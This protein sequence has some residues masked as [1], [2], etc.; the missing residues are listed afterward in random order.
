M[1]R[2]RR[3]ARPDGLCV[4]CVAVPAQGNAVTCYRCKAAEKVVPEY[5]N[6]P[7][8]WVRQVVPTAD[9]WKAI[10]EA[11]AQSIVWR[12]SKSG[13]GPKPWGMIQADVKRW[14]KLMHVAL[15]LAAEDEPWVR[16]RTPTRAVQPGS[17]P[18]ADCGDDKPRHRNAHRCAECQTLRQRRRALENERKRKAA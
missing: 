11:A 14:V 8:D 16:D 6:T 9:E 3:K 17:L 5:K 10:R 7:E 4:V 2:A 13:R 12:D 1:P 18:C 15:T